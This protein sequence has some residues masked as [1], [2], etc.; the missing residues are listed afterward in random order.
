MVSLGNLIKLC[1]MESKLSQSEL[2]N[3]I[4][5]VSYLSRIE[6]NMVEPHS[7]VYRLLLSRLNINIDH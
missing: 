6:N 2:A 4:V 5:S 1:R 3:G 7:E